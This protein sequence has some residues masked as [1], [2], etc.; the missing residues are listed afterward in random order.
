MMTKLRERSAVILWILVFAFVATII[1]AWGMGGFDSSQGPSDQGVMA[2]INGEKVDYRTFEQ[3]VIQRINQ[4]TQNSSAPVTPERVTQLRTRAWNDYLN[5]ALERQWAGERGMNPYDEEIV[6]HIRHNPPGD[7]AR[8]PEFLIDGKFD[9][10]KWIEV[11][12]DPQYENFVIQLEQSTRQTLALTKYR[13]LVFASPLHSEL[14]VWNDYLLKNQTV[15]VKFIKIPFQGIEIDSSE[16]S[17]ADLENRY[18]EHL[19]EYE[20]G[21]RAILSYVTLP[22]VTSAEDSVNILDDASYVL[23]R[24]QGGDNW[25]DLASAYSGDESNANNG[26]DL[27][28]FGR[29]N[30]VPPFEKQAFSMEPGDISPL[31][32]TSF[33]YHIIKMIERRINDAGEEEVHAAHILLKMAPSQA[34]FSYWAS[35]AEDFK[36]DSDEK[37]FDICAENAGYKLEVTS[38]IT[39]DGFLP[40]LGRHQRALDMVFHSEVGEVLYP[41][42]HQDSWYIYR[43]DSF[44]EPG[45]PSLSELGNRLWFQVK[46]DKQITRA[47]EQAEE[48]L[49]AN[50]GVSDLDSFTLSD[51]TLQVYMTE[52][53]FKMTDYV[54]D[55]GKD[56]LFNAAA[57][58]APIGAVIGP[59]QG[60]YGSYF[61]QVITR[62][63]D[64]AM[65]EKFEEEAEAFRDTYSANIDRTAYQRFITMLSDDATIE[66]NRYK[67]GRDY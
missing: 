37:G 57:F 15:Q 10:S 33:G 21:R 14:E 27:G 2:V 53:P 18:R 63:D 58:D 54:R 56:Y 12:T 7:L 1:F 24:V 60:K 44:I 9:S 25:D 16:I 11:L 66:D 31:V 51:T 46:R 4:E 17:E 35:L 47:Q 20:L 43:I 45:A 39:T 30:M 26:G 23:G 40:G 61:L 48:I 13:S 52:T 28:W 6:S 50:S 5:L 32:E 42:S 64:S 3:G 22:V 36:I 34:T 55:L 67:F 38:E 29:G 41:I 65:R 19:D 8:N 49:A 59:L 62:D